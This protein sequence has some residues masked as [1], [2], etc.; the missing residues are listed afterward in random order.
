M[1]KIKRINY[2]IFFLLKYVFDY[3]KMKLKEKIIIN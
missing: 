1:N 2:Q 3:V